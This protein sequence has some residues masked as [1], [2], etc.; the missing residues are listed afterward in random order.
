LREK[1]K[2]LER[3]KEQASI[4]EE[5]QQKD[6]K[7]KKPNAQEK[8]QR[9]APTKLREQN[10]ALK[11]ELSS[12]KEELEQVKERWMRAVADLENLKKRSTKEREDWTKYANEN[13]LKQIIPVI[14]NLQRA[15]D[16]E[17]SQR[18]EEAFW[19]GI[20]MIHRQFLSTLEGLGV[21]PIEALNKPFDPSI[22]EAI[23]QVESDDQEPNTVVQEMEKGYLLHDRLLRPSRV[24]VSKRNDS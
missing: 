3:Y 7:H 1:E 21:K 10:A 22:H 9:R 18:N 23:M 2:A 5:Q 13:L 11:R 17:N 14:D 24:V 8:G 20:E 19:E 15:L 16:H 4:E 12:L 6:V